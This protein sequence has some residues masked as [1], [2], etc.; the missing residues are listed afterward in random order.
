MADILGIA[1]YINRAGQQGRAQYEKREIGGSLG[2]LLSGGDRSAEMGNI[3]KVN[4]QAGMQVQGMMGKM[5]EQ[6]MERLG[7]QAAWFVSLPPDQKAAMYPQIASEAQA[8]GF[9]VPGDYRPDFDEAIGKLAQQFG[10]NDAPAGFAAVDMAARA[11]GFQPGTPKYQ[12]VMRIH[13]GLEPGYAKTSPRSITTDI[14]G[15]P[16]TL[17]YDPTTGGYTPAV[18]GGAPQQ[19]APQQ[20]VGGGAAYGG[21]QYG[22]GDE[23][24]AGLDSIAQV[25]SGFRTPEHN[26]KV[27]GVENSRHLDNMARD[28]LPPRTQEEAQRIRQFAAE[29]GLK[30]IDEGDHWHLQPPSRGGAAPAPA[31]S[32]PVTS[33]TGMPGIGQPIV[34][35]RKEDEAYA[36]TSATEQAR[37]EAEMRAANFR[38]GQEGRVAEARATAGARVGADVQEHAK[39]VELRENLPLLRERR[40]KLLEI[41]NGIKEG[42]IRTGPINKAIPDF[43]QS[44]ENQVYMAAVNEEILD[45]AERMTGILSDSDILLLKTTGFN[46]DNKPEANMAILGKKMDVLN[47]AISRAEQRTA[48]GSPLDRQQGVPAQGNRIRIKF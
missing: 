3:A 45:V 9:P 40:Q 16:T 35:R 43:L 17:N 20:Q 23:L 21:Q 26:A 11:A 32:P 47:R 37:I 22:S 48:Q 30:I 2:R 13:T 25:T 44:A 27:G 8:L 10:G 12:K 46:M 6:R 42:E 29:R 14:N 34:G 31:G 7:Q 41:Y 24:F 38:V 36:T 5:D 4:P 1:D 28:V 39:V 15:V 19:Y 18:I 33:A